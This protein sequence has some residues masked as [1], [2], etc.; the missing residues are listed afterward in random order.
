MNAHEHI[1]APLPSAR[2]LAVD[3]NLMLAMDAR[4]FLCA[5]QELTGGVLV[6]TERVFK[7]SWEKC[8]DVAAKP[9]ERA[10]LRKADESGRGRW[11]ADAQIERLTMQ[12]TVGWRHWVEA[13]R[14]NENAAWH[15]R[16]SSGHALNLQ[17]RLLTSSRAFK[18][19]SRFGDSLAVAEAMET[20]AHAI[21]S[22]NF[23][24]ILQD[25]FNEWLF[26]KKHLDGDQW[27]Q[28]VQV[29][30]ILGREA[31]VERRVLEVGACSPGEAVCR[32]ALGACLPKVTEDENVINA[33]LRR[34]LGNMGKGGLAH[35]A[36]DAADFLNALQNDVPAGW[37]ADLN[38]QRA[39]RTQGAEDRRLASVA[40][41][42]P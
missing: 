26:A 20:G 39:T 1:P 6:V 38:P 3:A 33:V 9:A 2:V 14:T 31:A 36:G 12:H 22:N 17:M 42:Q 4:R 11:D 29:P 13:E 34:F 8:A 40:E 15:Y 27:F 30:F 16:K 35:A 18:G 32:W 5:M 24:S 10:V 19:E 41:V 23:G 25:V 37:V 7:E 28:N 21:A